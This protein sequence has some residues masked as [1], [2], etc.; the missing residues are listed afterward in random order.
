LCRPLHAFFTIHIIVSILFAGWFLFLGQRSISSINKAAITNIGFAE[1]TE[2]AL[3]GLLLVMN[4]T[5]A[6]C[7]FHIVLQHAINAVTNAQRC[8]L[9]YSG[10]YKEKDHKHDCGAGDE[11]KHLVSKF[12][13]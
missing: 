1:M 4:T 9:C 11:C 13:D 7:M 2:M 8:I 12:Y 5:H 6:T 3:K 10:S